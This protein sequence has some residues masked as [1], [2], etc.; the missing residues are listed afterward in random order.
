MWPWAHR[1][2]DILRTVSLGDAEWRGARIH[3]HVVVIRVSA[4]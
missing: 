4:V 1:N 3:G 2:V